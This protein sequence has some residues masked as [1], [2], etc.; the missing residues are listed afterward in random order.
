MSFLFFS[1]GSYYNEAKIQNSKKI[2]LLLK[3]F[4]TKNLVLIIVEMNK[5]VLKNVLENIF[6]F[7][8]AQ[9]LNKL[10]LKK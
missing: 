2:K 1:K 8:S 9:S 7:L 10:H 4:A 5:K 3:N 6:L